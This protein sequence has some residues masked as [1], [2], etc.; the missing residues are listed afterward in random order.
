MFIGGVFYPGKT[1]EEISSCLDKIVKINCF[2]SIQYVVGK[3][4]EDGIGI[5]HIAPQHLYPESKIAKSGEAGLVAGLQGEVESEDVDSLV[6]K[7]AKLGDKLPGEIDG[8][9][10]LVVFEERVRRLVIMNDRAGI[11]PFYYQHCGDGF[12]F[13]TNIK[14]VLVACGRGLELDSLSVAQLFYFGHLLGDRTL[15]ASV[16]HLCQG[17]ILAFDKSVSIKRYWDPHFTVSDK[18]RTR[19]RIA[20][21]NSIMKNAVIKK[22]GSRTGVGLGLSGGLDS[23]M[24]AAAA[25]SANVDIK[26]FTVGEEDTNDFKYGREVARKLG[27]RHSSI[28][29]KTSSI[30]SFIPFI[31]WQIE[32]SISLEGCLSPLYHS[33][34]ISD[35]VR[36]KAGGACGDVLSGSHIKPYALLP[37]NKTRLIDKAL[38]QKRIIDKGLLDRTFSGGFHKAYHGQLK[39]SFYDSFSDIREDSFYKDCD[40][41]DFKNRQGRYI[42]SANQVDRY[43]FVNIEP[44]LDKDVME[45][46]FSVPTRL[47]FFQSLYKKAILAINDKIKD[48]PYAYT[49]FRIQRYIVIDIGLQA[50]L[51]ICKRIYRLCRLQGFDR[52]TGQFRMCDIIRSNTGYRDVLEDLTAAQFF[53][54]DILNKQA[55]LEIVKEHYNGAKDHSR[56]LNLLMTVLM[57]LKHFKSLSDIPG[58]I[59]EF[60]PKILKGDV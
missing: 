23:R 16:K 44:F 51:F 15:D 8:H 12:Y 6:S 25:E 29:A 19:A 56:L 50:A 52:K 2:S 45:F 17:S 18:E 20:R 10:N 3:Y 9:F 49:G 47:R 11:F 48:V 14:S 5:V 21:C 26:T 30:N 59:D 7:Y 38:S 42:F 37:I 35:G 54:S 1:R 31:C 60:V 39:K 41:W 40:I 24:V 43:Y 27:Y 4:V 57:T 33:Q 13:A 58:D 55:V 53:P 32:G 34:L 46:W 36:Y 22:F 28:N